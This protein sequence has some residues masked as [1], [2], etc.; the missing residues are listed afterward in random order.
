M[1]ESV[2]WITV[3]QRNAS[4][5][6]LLE[7]NRR[8]ELTLDRK[9]MQ[10]TRQNIIYSTKDGERHV[11]YTF[12]GNPVIHTEISNSFAEL[13]KKYQ[14]AIKELEVTQ[15]YL[16]QIQSIMLSHEKSTASQENTERDH[17][18]IQGLF[19]AATISYGK[20]FMSVGQGR[21]KFAPRD[22]FNQDGS[23][24]KELHSW[25]MDMRNL[26]IAHS[27]SEPYDDARVVL[28]FEP[29]YIGPSEWFWCFP[30]V[31]FHRNPYVFSPRH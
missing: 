4:T 13:A 2:C 9:Y 26:Y 5:Q 22:F 17:I 7:P 19:S 24:F 3:Q 10:K 16:E 18:V 21:R 27:A 29:I 25:W 8:L 30:H 1:A 20:L 11:S 23:Q 6:V 28:L 14:F 31:R 12:D 15:A